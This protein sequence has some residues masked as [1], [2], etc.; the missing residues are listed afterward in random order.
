MEKKVAS[1]QGKNKKK[2]GSQ[3]GSGMKIMRCPTFQKT[4][5]TRALVTRTEY[6]FR[7]VLANEKMLSDSGEEVFVGESLV[8]LTPLAAKELNSQLGR[9]IESWEKAYGTIKKRPAE[10][11]YSEQSLPE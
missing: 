3:S 5:G 8:I 2:G 9:L 10:S 1:V 4:Y 7:V 6:D 11:I